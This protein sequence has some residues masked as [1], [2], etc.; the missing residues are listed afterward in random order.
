MGKSTRRTVRVPD[1]RWQVLSHRPAGDLGSPEAWDQFITSALRELFER[2]PEVRKASPSQHAELFDEY[3]LFQARTN[4]G[5]RIRLSHYVQS[6]MSRWNVEDSGPEKFE[7]L[8][9]AEAHCA[10]ILQGIAKPPITDP[11]LYRGKKEMSEELRALFRLISDFTR[12]RLNRL[13]MEELVEFIKESVASDAVFPL[14]WLNRDALIEYVKGGAGG[15][16]E[17]LQAGHRP[18]PSTFCDEWMAARTRHDPERF[19]QLVSKIGSRKT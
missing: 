9:K 14:L 6:R 2:E 17:Q 16:T 10:R 1:F 3:I 8:G 13:A 18:S 15:R 5:W 7:R 4:L 19:R 11:D 12:K